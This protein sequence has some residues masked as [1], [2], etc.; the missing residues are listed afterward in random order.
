M[1]FSSEKKMFTAE[2]KRAPRRLSSLSR[3]NP[4][5]GL[6]GS[7][8]AATLAASGGRSSHDL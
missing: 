8:L 1:D 6:S 4:L 3:N 2:L 5:G 7:A